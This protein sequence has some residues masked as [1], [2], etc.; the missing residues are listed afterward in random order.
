MTET[1]IT[2]AHQSACLRT[3]G[4]SS[5]GGGNAYWLARKFESKINI[6]KSAMLENIKSNKQA[7]IN[8]PQCADWSNGVA[9][10]LERALEI[11]NELHP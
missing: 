5:E 6:A 7:A 9:A 4:R 3:G 10:G 1:P 8:A 2:D 11:I